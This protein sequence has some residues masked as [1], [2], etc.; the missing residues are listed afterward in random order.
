MRNVPDIEPSMALWWHAYHDLKTERPPGGLCAIPYF[1]IVHY[2][3]YHKLDLGLLK[4]IIWGLDSIF[5]EHERKRIEAIGK[6]RQQQ[7]N[8]DAR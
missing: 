5:I 8:K 4:Q 1:A 6:N 3:D 2:A 7:G